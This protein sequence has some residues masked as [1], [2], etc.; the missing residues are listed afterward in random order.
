VPAVVAPKQSET[1][2]GEGYRPHLDGLRAVAV[3]LVVAFH[4][5]A[6]R[7]SG[8]FIGVD[9][10]FVLSGYLVTQL[11]LRDLDSRGTVRFGRFYARRIRRLLPAAF[12]ALVITAVVYSAVASQAEISTSLNGFKAAFLYVANWFFIRR[13]TNYFA[14][15]ID[16][17]PVVHFWSL[18]IEEQFY[19]LW[20]ILLTGLF[21]ATRPLRQ[22]AT[23][24]RQAAVGAGA[25]AS[26][27]WAL[28]LAHT[29]LNRAYYGTD[30]RAYQ[31]LAGALLA[32]CPSLFQLARRYRFAPLAAFVATVVLLLLSTS[33]IGVNAIHRGV[34]ATITTVVL[35]VAIECA[36]GGPVNR[37][38]SS[39]PVVYLGKIS[40]GTY[41]WHWPV[42]LV[43]LAVTNK[44]ISPESTFGLSALAATGLASLSYHILELP[45]RQHRFLDQ[46]NPAVIAAGLTI[47]V[48]AALVIVPGILDP[49]RSQAATPRTTSTAGFTPVPAMSFQTARSDIGS[50]L[51]HVS[52]LKDWNC[53]GKPSAACT[54][55]KG[56]GPHIL[57]IGDSHAHMFF[58]TFAKIA[59]TRHLT[60][61]TAATPGCPWQR[62][63]YDSGFL[64]EDPTRFKRCSDM[65]R[66][67]YDRVIPELKPDLVVAMSNDY[68]TGRPGT[69]RDRNGKPIPARTPAELRTVIR[70]ETARS[71]EELKK[72]AGKVM[73]IDPVP[74][75]D[76]DPLDCLTK[77]KVLEACRYVAN[78]HPLPIEQVYRDLADKR[79]VFVADF[80]Q[81]TCPFLPICDPV[82]DGRI[83][84]YDFQHLT[85][86][87]AET[88][89]PEVT[90]FL[91]GSGLI[92]R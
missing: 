61:S 71:L 47:G 35:I 3:Y 30:T 67:L 68:L 62:N 64:P 90:A 75:A 78:L 33:L 39:G 89:A 43:A 86:L 10:F 85:P 19:L 72:S 84:R 77:S 46:V 41:L 56:S 91:Q 9:V 69:V 52:F 6:H 14:A 32:L 44:G 88:L 70:A 28:S 48:V 87:Y 50:D 81:L 42:I 38:L 2:A 34:A 53:R 74:L 17:N 27:L 55:V 83:V 79:R 12:A 76:I 80:D 59:V 54:I 45:I 8:G 66:D 21:A 25:L 22:Q 60:L 92:P 4:A 11:L 31:L 26:M 1:R 40:Y 82:V 63:L 65:K 7:F 23:R 13:S 18:A 16:T 20:P 49:Y 5:G 15:N 36:R 51:E 24:V 57:V 29:N 58:P 73:I 37:L